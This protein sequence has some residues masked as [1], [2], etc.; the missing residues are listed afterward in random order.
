MYNPSPRTGLAD[1]RNAGAENFYSDYNRQSIFM[2][3]EKSMLAKGECIFCKSENL[4]KWG[5]QA[6]LQ[7]LYCS[8]CKKTFNALTGTPFAHLR[9]REEWSNMLAALGNSLSLHKTAE[10]CGTAATTALRWRHRF[11]K[12]MRD[13]D[14]PVSSKPGERTGAPEGAGAICRRQ[15]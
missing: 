5:K 6:G 15:C 2:Y 13:E 8:D 14:V 3:L 4:V 7:R 12:A 10:I 1:S 11:L 9:K